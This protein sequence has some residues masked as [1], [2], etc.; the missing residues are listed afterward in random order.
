MNT[1]LREFGISS[2]TVFPPN[3]YVLDDWIQINLGSTHNR[4]VLE[5]LYQCPKGYE[6][7]VCHP[8]LECCQ[9]RPLGESTPK[10]HIRPH[11][12]IP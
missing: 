1:L 11:W 4:L 6:L 2:L 7:L 3:S 5:Y 10:E 9:S 12:D 8:K